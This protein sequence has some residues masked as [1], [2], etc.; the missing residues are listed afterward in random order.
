M[1]KVSLPLWEVFCGENMLDRD[2]GDGQLNTDAILKATRGTTVISETLPVSKDYYIGPE[3][4]EKGYHRHWG[5]L[6]RVNSLEFFLLTDRDFFDIN[7]IFSHLPR[8][9]IEFYLSSEDRTDQVRILD[10]GGGRDGKT[11]K[12]I[13]GK[14]SQTQV[15]NA[16]LV[17]IP[18]I[19]NNFI[20][21]RTDLGN[22][23]LAEES[24]DLA[25]SHQ[26]LPFMLSER[27]PDKQLQAV[28]G[29]VRI[30]KPGGVGLIDWTDQPAVGDA[31]LNEIEDF[32]VTVIPQQKSYGGVFLFIAKEPAQPVVSSMSSYLQIPA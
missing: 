32:G 3:S 20:S 18:D 23:P 17:A 30:L 24:I 7:T 26:V 4:F 29:I 19:D 2:L 6:R 1:T 25:Y 5:T 14:Y 28:Q 12:E 27:Y 9:L 31:T 13:A 21:I 11:A 22:L 8:K 16:D 10:A 15:I